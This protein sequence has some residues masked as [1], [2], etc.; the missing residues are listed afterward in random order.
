MSDNSLLYNYI[1]TVTNFM[2]ALAIGSSHTFQRW[3][4]SRL[5]LWII[6][7]LWTVL[8]MAPRARAALSGSFRPW[9][10]RKV[11][12]QFILGNS[13]RPFAWFQ[14]S[15]SNQH[16]PHPHLTQKQKISDLRESHG[17]YGNPYLYG[18]NHIPVL[19]KGCLDIFKKSRIRVPVR[20]HAIYVFN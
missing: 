3:F 10:F 20:K 14:S 2:T 13:L 5:A 6:W 15:C 17:K 16:H 9:C 12:S 1:T 19:C 7:M 18:K 11:F 8:Q 4:Y